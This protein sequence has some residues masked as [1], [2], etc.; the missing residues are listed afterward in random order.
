MRVLGIDPGFGRVGFGIIDYV[1]G[2][3]VYV[4]SEC[5]ETSPKDA[6]VHRLAAVGKKTKEICSTWKPDT[7]AIETLFFEKNQK[8]A[9]HVAEARG[10]IVYESSQM[11]HVAE[12]TPLQIKMALTGY[13]KATKDQVTFMVE[14]IISLP[15][16]VRLDDE[17]DALAIAITHGAF[18]RPSKATFPLA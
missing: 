5:F 12:Y 13:G 10:V 15:L 6:F 2:K 17:L 4:Y 9:M 3:E 18:Y 7:I 11:A 1:N 16:G 14:K 8:T